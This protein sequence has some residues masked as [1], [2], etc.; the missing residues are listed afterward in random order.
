MPEL[1]AAD[2]RRQPVHRCVTDAARA[3]Y[4]GYDPGND[5]WIALAWA[6][7]ITVVFAFLAIRKFA[8][9]DER[10]T[11]SVVWWRPDRAATKRQTGGRWSRGPR[12]RGGTGT[13]G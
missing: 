5:V 8:R 3:L 12:A 4:N 9:I 11:G 13:R 1:A 7:G 6:V 10:L 2:R